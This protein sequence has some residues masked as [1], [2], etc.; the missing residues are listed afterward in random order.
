MPEVSS[1]LTSNVVC[2]DLDQK[3]TDYLML[4]WCELFGVVMGRRNQSTTGVC[5][6]QH[7]NSDS[8][9]AI[10][11]DTK[12]ITPGRLYFDCHHMDGSI[13]TVE[14]ILCKYIANLQY[15]TQYI[16]YMNYT[17]RI[18]DILTIHL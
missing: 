10:V 9:T 7:D 15:N 14:V 8:A 11:L 3:T 2:I 13:Q 16:S 17:H 5:T 6:T 4:P 18:N 12:V 1:T